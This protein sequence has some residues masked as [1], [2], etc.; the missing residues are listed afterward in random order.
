[1]ADDKNDPRPKFF[2]D[3]HD[4][5]LEQEV[6]AYVIV[7]VVRRN[8]VFSIATG[9]GSRLNEQH[10]AVGKVYHAM[11]R[12]FEEAMASLVAPA[13]PDGTPNPPN[14]GLLN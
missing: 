7:G 12:A 2:A 11:D 3:V 6:L 10:E 14:G 8:N 13:E 1:M 9:A 4:L 5:A